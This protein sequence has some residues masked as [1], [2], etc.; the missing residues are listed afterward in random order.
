MMDITNQ[1]FG[2][3]T[4]IS[5]VKKEN[6]KKRYWLCQCSCGNQKTVRMD[7]LLNGNT[8]SCGHLKKQARP[9][10]KVSGVSNRS[11]QH[12][13]EKYGK[14][15]IVDYD[16]TKTGNTYLCICKCDCGAIKKVRFNNLKNGITTSCGCINSKGEEL[17]GKL[18]TKHNISY[19]KEYSFSNC[20]SPI[21]GHPYRFDFY[22]DNK[23]LIEYDGIQHFKDTSLNWGEPLEQLQ[24]RDKIKNEW[25]LN[26]NIPLIRI[27]YIHLPKLMIE[28]LL[29]T[30]SS[31]I[32]TKS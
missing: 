5:E 2:E 19:S 8:R 18:L 22:V 30:T 3:L 6:T 21:T 14:L 20:K 12:I 32:V 15:T 7:N 10:S 28:D 27:P 25:C 24:Q 11:L 31:F 1:T 26:N 29:L 4:A 13:G 23:Y 16:R 17:I 9:T